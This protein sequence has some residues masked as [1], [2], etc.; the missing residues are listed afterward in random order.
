MIQAIAGVAPADLSETTIMTVWPTLAALKGGQWWGRRYLNNTGVTVFGIPL[1]IGRLTALASI[2]LILPVYFLTLLPFLFW[3]PKLGRFP[4]RSRLYPTEHFQ[5]RWRPG[6]L[7]PFHGVYRL[8]PL[9]RRYRLTNRR[10]IVEHGMSAAEQRS[11]TLDEFDSIDVVVQPG[12]EWYPAGDLVF[13][14]GQVET[15]RLEGV[16]RP[17]AF[18]HVC[19]KAQRAHAA[20]KRALSRQLTAV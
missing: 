10:V 11:V 4:G 6:K 7:G 19:L 12:Q 13:R 2:P 15:F 5:S 17:E 1:T 3:L 20:V 16:S 14:N 18:R 9:C 8:N